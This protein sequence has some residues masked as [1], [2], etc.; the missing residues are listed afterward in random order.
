QRRH[1]H[2][3]TGASWDRGRPARTLIRPDC[4]AV[5]AQ[6]YETR[7]S[8]RDARGPR[9]RDP[10]MLNIGNEP[11]RLC[12]GL[13]RRSFLTVGAAG[14]GAL[15]LPTFFRFQQAGAADDKKAKIRNCITLFLV[16]SP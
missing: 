2:Q 12:E 4:D 8:G 13:T 3:L 16:G 7:S 6:R 15:A 1:L 9:I 11:V 14:A 5:V 10:I